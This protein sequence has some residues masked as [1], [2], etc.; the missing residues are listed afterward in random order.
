MK[1]GATLYIAEVQ[2]QILSAQQVVQITNLSRVTI[3]RMERA[4]TF[5][6]R[7]NISPNRVGWR[8]DDINEWRDKN[9]LQPKP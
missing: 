6:Q 7:I 5:P 1:K 3:W 4:R 2:M 9:G 8:E